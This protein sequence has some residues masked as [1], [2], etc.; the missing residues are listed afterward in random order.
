MNDSFHPK[1]R[2]SAS[3]AGRIALCLFAMLLS[4]AVMAQPPA[5]KGQGK[6]PPGQSKGPMPN[7][8]DRASGGYPDNGMA[9]DLVRAGIT[10]AAAGRMM[11]D[12][13]ISLAGYKPLPPG[14]R[15]TLARGKPL[16]P[17]IAQ[18]RLPG[19]FVDRLPAYPGY[20]WIGAGTDLLLIQAGSRIIAD[21]LVDVF[22]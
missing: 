6:G 16:P 4:A 7:A 17:G 13:G 2:A 3:W 5:G 10:A 8:T 20:E 19:S 14:I 22:R 15:R 21:V 9:L 11:D 1:V 12:L 18:Q